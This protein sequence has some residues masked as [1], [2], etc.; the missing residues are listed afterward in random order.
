VNLILTI[1]E[2]VWQMI[3]DEFV[4]NVTESLLSVIFK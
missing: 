3:A 2:I 4:E 1:I